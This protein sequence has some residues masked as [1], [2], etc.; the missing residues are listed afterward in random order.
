MRISTALVAQQS[1]EDSK[2]DASSATNQEVDEFK[3]LELRLQKAQLP[4]AASKVAIRELNRLRHLQSSQSE[5]GVLR[6]Y[7]DWLADLPWNSS[8]VDSTDLTKA[9]AILDADHF[10][11]EKI[12]KR[13]LE[14]LAV[15]ALRPNL[16]S[17]IL[18][19]VGPP[20]TGKVSCFYC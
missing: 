4:E 7:L 16:P 19:F 15:R 20:G 11:L 10:G 9:Q 17:P 13:L 1:V 2:K 8:T 12:K 5:Y 3:E 6:N 18:C 14:F